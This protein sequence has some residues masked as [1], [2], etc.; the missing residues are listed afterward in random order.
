MTTLYRV[1]TTWSYTPGGP[2][3]SNLYFGTTDPLAAGAQTAVNDVQAF[4]TAIKGLIPS[5]V[6]LQVDPAVIMVEDV[7]SEQVG[8]VLVGSTPAPIVCT[9][10]GSMAAP[11]GATAQ[12]STASYLYGRRVKGRTYL[13]PLASSAFESNGTIISG[14]LTTL[15]N[16]AAALVAGGSNLVV[17]TRKREYKAADP[18][19]GQKEVTARA[20]ASSL[21]VSGAVRDIVA[22][23]RSRRD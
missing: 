8:D 2:G 5:I 9:A 11:A 4:F 10:T 18:A 19:K 7:T 14:A 17:F 15:N 16:A 20:G 1:R 3:Y 13:V 22:V 12:W 6:T 23:L 21:V